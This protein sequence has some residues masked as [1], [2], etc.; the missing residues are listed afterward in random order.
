MKREGGGSEGIPNAHQ[1]VKIL[2]ANES[3]RQQQLRIAQILVFPVWHENFRAIF[4]V[5]NR[6][7]LEKVLFTFQMV[8]KIKIN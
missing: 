4:D 2:L 3:I 1:I 7:V 8:N 5:Q 6:V